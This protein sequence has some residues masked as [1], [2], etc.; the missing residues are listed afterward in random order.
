MAQ[1]LPGYWPGTSLTGDLSHLP[2]D[3]RLPCLPMEI[4]NRQFIVDALLNVGP[5]CLNEK[6][7]AHS[8]EK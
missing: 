2:G 1:I 5:R 4:N 6:T 8:R 7:S 3:D